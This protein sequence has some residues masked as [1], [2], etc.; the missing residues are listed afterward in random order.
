RAERAFLTVVVSPLVQVSAPRTVR[1]IHLSHVRKTLN[2]GVPAH[3]LPP[4]LDGVGQWLI[5][6]RE[7]HLPRTDPC[8]NANRAATCMPK[9][10]PDLRKCQPDFAA[11]FPYGESPMN[12]S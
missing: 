6:A 2:P 11:Y 3:L 9:L 5:V 12:A 4:S 7:P 8:R 1:G 10:D